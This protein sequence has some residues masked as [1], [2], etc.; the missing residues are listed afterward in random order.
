M[1]FIF[2]VKLTAATG[3]AFK[4]QKTGILLINDDE[5]TGD[6][7]KNEGKPAFSFNEF[8][9]S[10][11]DHL[12]EQVVYF[13]ICNLHPE[14]LINFISTHYPAVLTPPPNC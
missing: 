4:T 13:T 10:F 12:A 2:I 7:K 8:L 1:L 14:F 3:S 11:A 6:D 5:D 9:N